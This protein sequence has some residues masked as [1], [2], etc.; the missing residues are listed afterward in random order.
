MCSYFFDVQE[1]TQ[2]RR[3]V[4]SSP[5]CHLSQQVFV[6]QE[7]TLLENSQ[8]QRPVL[9]RS[10]SAADQMFDVGQGDVLKF[11]NIAK[12]PRSSQHNEMF[13]T[14]GLR[15]PMEDFSPEMLRDAHNPSISLGLGDGIS[16][17]M[18]MDVGDPLALGLG[19]DLELRG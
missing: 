16:G 10:N 8:S 12:S 6:V 9:S 3:E 14:A 11:E 19:Q 15:D 2:A 17:G 1:S 18:D 4:G 7:I 13:D 5:S